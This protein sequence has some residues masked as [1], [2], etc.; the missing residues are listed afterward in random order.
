M[1]PLQ[2]GGSGTQVERIGPAAPGHRPPPPVFA[3]KPSTCIEQP[4]RRIGRLDPR[5]VLGAEE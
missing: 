1:E 2:A 5:A 4:D 3:V